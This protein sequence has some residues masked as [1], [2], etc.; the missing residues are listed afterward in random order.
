MNT[1]DSINE[2]FLDSAMRAP[3]GIDAEQQTPSPLLEGFLVDI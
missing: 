1:P 3:K 2:I